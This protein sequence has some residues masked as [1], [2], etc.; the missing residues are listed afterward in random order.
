MKNLF[1]AASLLFSVQAFSQDLM[2]DE[3]KEMFNVLSHHQVQE[4]MKDFDGKLV[5][6][7]I[8][9]SVFRCP[10]CN[11]YVLSGNKLN[12]DIASPEKTVITI[13]GRGVLGFGGH[14]VQTY[15][16]SVKN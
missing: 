5:N 14:F 16:C 3:A 12:I 15:E 10:G 1:L 13:K 11:T 2:G 8:K 4:C 9:K 6:L 7:S